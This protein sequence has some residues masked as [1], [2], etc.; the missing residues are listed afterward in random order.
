MSQASP[1]ST[2]LSERWFSHKGETGMKTDLWWLLIR[3]ALSV[4]DVWPVLV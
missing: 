4:F 2:A 1:S 3:F